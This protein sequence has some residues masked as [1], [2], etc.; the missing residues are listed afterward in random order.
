MWIVANRPK[1][2][3]KVDPKTWVPEVA[4]STFTSPDKPRTHDLTI[5]DKGDIWVVLGNDSKNYKEGRPGLVKYDG[6]TGAVLMT[7]DFAPGSADPHGLEWHDGALVSCDAGIHP[8]WPNG[9]SP[10]K[11]WIFR[12]DLA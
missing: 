6:K 3:L 9:H 2:L 8:G 10:H 11:G 7:C 1:L 4:I 5:D 12:I